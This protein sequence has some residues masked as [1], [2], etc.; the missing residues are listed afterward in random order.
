MIVATRAQ[1]GSMVFVDI[2]VR[3]LGNII[4]LYLSPTSYN[5]SQSFDFNVRY[6]VHAL[7]GHVVRLPGNQS[8]QPFVGQTFVYQEIP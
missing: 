5:I 8:G 1:Y 6:I 7:A 3:I 4:V 2:F